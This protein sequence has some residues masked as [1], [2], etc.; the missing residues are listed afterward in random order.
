[1][2]EYICA[3]FRAAPVSVGS[4][5]ETLLNCCVYN[6]SVLN[7]LEKNSFSRFRVQVSVDRYLSGQIFHVFACTAFFW[8]VS[9]AVVK[10]FGTT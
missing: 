4:V 1:M 7:V 6:S 10:G 5:I 2:W 3:I 9:N 8:L